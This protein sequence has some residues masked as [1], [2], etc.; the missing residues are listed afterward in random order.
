MKTKNI[1]VNGVSVACA[2]EAV[3][4]SKT[5]HTHIELT[6]QVDSTQTTHRMT[7][8]SVDEPVPTTYGKE[9]LQAEFEKFRLSCAQ[10]VESKHRIKK[11]ALSVE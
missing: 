4:D 9:Q 1:E 5:A 3:H 7:I 10:M 6:V 8:G 2:H 11:L